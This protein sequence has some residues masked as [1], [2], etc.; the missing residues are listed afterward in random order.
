MSRN[1]K[2]AILVALLLIVMG[3]ILAM[4]GYTM[5]GN[6]LTQ[7]NT[8]EL[9][10]ETY[11][12][13]EPFEHIHI[14]TGSSDVRI[15]PSSDGSCT[16][17]CDDESETQYHTVSVEDGILLIHQVTEPMF[18]GVMLQYDP[19]VTVYLPESQYGNLVVDGAAGSI[20]DVDTSFTF[21]SARL[22]LSSGDIHFRASLTHDLRVRT[23]SGDIRLSGCHVGGN[24]Q[25]DASSGSIALSDLNTKILAVNGSSGDI[26][27]EDIHAQAIQTSASS[28]SIALSGCEAQQD[29]SIQT[30][31]G[32]VELTEVTAPSL[33]GNASSG[34]FQLQE[35]FIGGQLFLETTSGSIFFDASDAQSLLINTS[36]GEVSGTLL[37]PKFFITHTSSGSVKTSDSDPAGGRCEITTSSGDIKITAE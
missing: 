18:F 35:T 30:T 15:L 16:V 8:E 2:T 10:Q 24:T 4:I 5:T 23:S 22:T 37:S 36:S 14:R 6:D 21:E 7:L 20:L 33:T 25:V 12:I 17:V 26:L 27:L 29:L 28:G 3:G 11:T 34:Y 31:S 9:T 19:V 1:K 13:T 32:S